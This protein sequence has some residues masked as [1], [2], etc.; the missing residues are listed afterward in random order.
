[1]TAPAVTLAAEIERE[2]Q[3]TDYCA[4]PRYDAACRALAA[5]KTTDEVKDIRNRAEAMRAYAR[6]A[7]NKQLEV[8]AAE[9]RIRAERRLGELIKAQKETVGLN[10]GAKGSIVTGSVREPVKDDRPTLADAGID[11]KLSSRA[12]KLAAVPE[13]K[14]EGLVAEWRVRVEQEN[15]RVTMALLADS[16]A[17]H[18]LRVMGSSESTEWYTPSHIVER[19]VATLGQIDTD[20]S[21]HPD[22]PVQARSTYTANDDGLAQ[23][24]NGRVYLN[25]PYGR[26]IDA[27]ITKLVDEYQAGTVSEAIALVP[28]RVD[29]EWFRRLDPFLRC[30]L[31]GRLTFANAS[32]PAPFPSAVV[33]LGSNVTRFSEVFRQV[34]S[35]FARFD[36]EA[37]IKPGLV[38][39]LCQ[40]VGDGTLVGL[41]ADPDGESVEITGAGGEYV[42]LTTTLDNTQVVGMRRPVRAYAV[43]QVLAVIGINPRALSWKFVPN[44]PPIGLRE[45]LAGEARS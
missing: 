34:G 22:S 6:Q 15:E 44:A 27:W 37:A 33:Y 41:S 4:L 3:A 7:K 39:G 29:T 23:R 18:A 8:D 40:H 2:H 28:A 26:E 32:N 21:W 35:I 43:D 1:M 42:W 17:S 12:Q 38:A 10:Q 9:I 31:H 20:P 5:A 13:A 36:A 24:W 11:K 45:M 30:F 25:P 19:V 16:A 14:F